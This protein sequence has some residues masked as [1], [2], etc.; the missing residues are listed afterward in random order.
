MATPTTA[1]TPATDD[2]RARKL[3]TPADVEREYGIAVNTIYVW[4][5]TDRYGFRSIGLK[6]GRNLRFRR[7]D[8]ERWLESRRGVA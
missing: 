1:K 2:A 8:I 4:R 5:S 6:I 7:A 3:L